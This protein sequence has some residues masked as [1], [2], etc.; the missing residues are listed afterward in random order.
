MKIKY[1]SASIFLAACFGTA[2]AQTSEPTARTASTDISLRG[3]PIQVTFRNVKPETGKIW[4]SLCSEEE[5]PERDE[6][7]CRGRVQIEASEGAQYNFEGIEAGV[8]ALT[9]YHDEDGNGWLDFDTR[10]L[11]IEATGNSRNAVG[12]FGP[13]TFDQMQFELMPVE[14]RAKPLELVVTLRRLTIP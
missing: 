11:P 12:S 10:G 7:K 3:Q 6:G 14:N 5:F 4:I 2:C 1:L 9:A 8:Y 13:P